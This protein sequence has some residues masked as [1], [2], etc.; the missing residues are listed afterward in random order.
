VDEKVRE[1]A[2]ISV[3]AFLCLALAWAHEVDFFAMF[4]AT[5][6]AI[7]GVEQ[8]DNLCDV[9]DN[10][11]RGDRAWVLDYSRPISPG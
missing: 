7:A 3:V 2:L 6:A 5:A 9:R 4:F 10:R 8:L 1:L 11:A